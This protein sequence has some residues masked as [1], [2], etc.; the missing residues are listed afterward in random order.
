MKRST[1]PECEYDI[2]IIGGGACGLTA[3]LALGQA[4]FRVALADAGSHLH[5]SK[6]RASGAARRHTPN[7]GRSTAL[8]PNSLDFLEKLGVWKDIAKRAAPIETLDIVACNTWGENL[9][10]MR[11]DAPLFS[12]AS[13]TYVSP[14]DK[15][16]IRIRNNLVRN[17]LAHNIAHGDL[18]TALRKKVAQSSHS[19][20]FDQHILT[21]FVIEKTAAKAIFVNGK[22]ITAGLIVA[23]DGRQSAA[24]HIAG[25]APDP[26][27]VEKAAI[28]CV[29]DQTPSSGHKTCTEFHLEEGPLTLTPLPPVQSGGTLRHRLALVWVNQP[30]KARHL[31]EADP[32]VFLAALHAI[33]KE[34]IGATARIGSRRLYPIRPFLVSRLTGPRFVLAGESAHV[35]PP[36]GAQGLNLSLADIQILTACLENARD[37]GSR[38]TGASHALAD[39][40]RQRK[41]DIWIRSQASRGLDRWA[42]ARNPA[43]ITI[44]AGITRMLDKTNLFKRAL[45]EL[46]NQSIPG[47]GYLSCL[48]QKKQRLRKTQ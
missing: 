43:E 33:A 27:G 19:D 10:R 32:E 41:T 37:L 20:L 13:T 21:D 23:A 6:D 8:L 36:T 46:A 24:R 35:L 40:A 31:L 5:K 48:H 15:N 22:V 16:R 25:I 4:G 3:T 30:G 1:K 38:D 34:K 11:F 17:S 14:T 12:N 7:D 9:S 29:V 28:V 42:S 18:I 39:Y 26:K 45:T 2:L 47:P 44:R